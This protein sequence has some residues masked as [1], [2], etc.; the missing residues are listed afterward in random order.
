M[1][2]ILILTAADVALSESTTRM[3]CGGGDSW[4]MPQDQAIHVLSPLSCYPLSPPY[5]EQK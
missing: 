3:D 1:S 4:A 5:T 2:I